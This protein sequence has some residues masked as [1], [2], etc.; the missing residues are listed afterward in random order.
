MPEALLDISRWIHIVL[1]GWTLLSGPAALMVRKGSRAHIL[2]GRSFGMAMAVVC[3]S[4]LFN[5]IA[6]QLVFLCMIAVFSAYNISSGWMALRILKKQL[7]PEHT[8][9]AHAIGALSMLCFVGLGFYWLFVLRSTGV[10]L[11]SLFFGGIGLANVWSFSRMR[12]ADP[13]QLMRI[14]ISRFVSGFI[15]SLSAFSVQTM[16]FIPGLLRW[17]WPT[18]ALVPVI[19]FWTRKYLPARPLSAP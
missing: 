17:T 12:K 13:K 18:F 2:L 14:H 7:R 5:G 6:H 10:G 3:A 4:A 1:G 11:L 9:L 15:A 8:L 16:D 19:V